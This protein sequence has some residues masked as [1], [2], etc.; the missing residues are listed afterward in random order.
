MLYNCTIKKNYWWLSKQANICTLE[1][2]VSSCIGDVINPEA[3]VT[4]IL[5]LQMPIHDLQAYPCS[6]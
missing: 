4:A 2:I 1:F 3:I 5:S 6:L